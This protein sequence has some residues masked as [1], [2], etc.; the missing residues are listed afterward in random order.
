[1]KI[2]FK[3]FAMM[4]AA[5]W[6]VSPARAVEINLLNVNL[7]SPEG[8]R[9]TQLYGDAY[10]FSPQQVAPAMLGPAEEVPAVLQIAQ[11]AGTVPMTVWMMRRMGMSYGSILSNFALAPAALMGAPL[12]GPSL[13]GFAPGWASP[14]WSQVTNPL[15]IEVARVRFLRNVLQVDPFFLPQIPYRGIGFTRSILYPYH[16]ERGLWLPPG[17]AKKYGLWIPPGQAKKMG[18]WGKWEVDDDDWNGRGKWKAKD[19][20]FETDDD[21]GSGWKRSGKGKGSKSLSKSDKGH[22]GKGKGKGK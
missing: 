16:P 11:A 9:A 6:Y 21:D 15:L 19:V 12:G 4:I 5:L 7:G 2:I 8:A 14:G 20:K 10:G 1:M 3:A 18:G 17:I 13:G 22:G